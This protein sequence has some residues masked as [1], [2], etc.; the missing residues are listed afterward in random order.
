VR[1]VPREL[2]YS[3]RGQWSADQNADIFI[4]IHHDSNGGASGTRG[5]FDN[6]AAVNG[7]KLA[8]CLTDAVHTEFNVPYSHNPHA[9]DWDGKH[10]GVLVGGRNW[11]V[12]GA[13]CLI[14]MMFVSN[15]DDAA[16]IKA[17]DYPVRA[18]HALATGIYHYAGLLIPAA[19]A[20]GVV[21]PAPPA[22]PPEFDLARKWCVDNGITSGADP[23]ASVTR[24]ML[25]TMLY[26][27]RGKMG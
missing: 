17:D 27:A 13:A 4:S 24:E 1:D 19:W 18:A 20:G 23:K 3:A 8:D 16:K 25:W 9:S 7:M 12:T 6:P 22:T 26:R 11:A 14:E 5:I 2:G 21:P 10:L 15:P